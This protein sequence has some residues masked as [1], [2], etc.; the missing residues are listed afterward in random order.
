MSYR[1]K[2]NSFLCFSLSQACLIF[3]LLDLVANT[4]IITRYS[5]LFYEIQAPENLSFVVIAAISVCTCSFMIVGSMMENHWMLIPHI[6]WKTV[7]IG[8]L[9]VLVVMLNLML[10][11]NRNEK[12][13]LPVIIIFSIIFVISIPYWNV[14]MNH[15]LEIKNKP[16]AHL[17]YNWSTNTS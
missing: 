9:A 10:I 4:F 2:W 1:F 7:L 11:E 5:V 12:G 14:M 13:L 15:Y 3:N 16:A 6:L 17:M 8:C